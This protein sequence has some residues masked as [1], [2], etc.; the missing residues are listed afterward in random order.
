MERD[1]NVQSGR[2]GW[3]GQEYRESTQKSHGLICAAVKSKSR[4]AP[5]T[6]WGHPTWPFPESQKNCYKP[7]EHG[8]AALCSHSCAWLCGSTSGTHWCSH[9][10]LGHRLAEGLPT[11]LCK[12]FSNIRDKMLQGFF[13]CK[14][15]LAFPTPPSLQKGNSPVCISRSISPVWACSTAC[16]ALCSWEL[17]RAAFSIRHPLVPLLCLCLLTKMDV[18]LTD[19]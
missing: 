11:H 1:S 18:T 13:C 8:H 14:R 16:S 4:L 5:Q 12:H 15:G 2:A 6:L 9:T 19:L 7:P 3:S 10:A 17:K